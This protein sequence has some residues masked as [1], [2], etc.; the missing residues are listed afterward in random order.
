MEYANAGSESRPYEHPKLDIS[1]RAQVP[2]SALESRLHNR[3]SDV[4][5]LL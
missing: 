1:I 3:Q 4:S 5:G 2:A